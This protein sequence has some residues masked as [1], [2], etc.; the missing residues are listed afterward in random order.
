M[1][2]EAIELHTATTVTR[3]RCYLW[4]SDEFVTLA[5]KARYLINDCHGSLDGSAEVVKIKKLD[6]NRFRLVITIG[7]DGH[8]N[9]T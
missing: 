1:Y 2:L 9:V 3:R 6:E 4:I 7:K 5:I 8:V